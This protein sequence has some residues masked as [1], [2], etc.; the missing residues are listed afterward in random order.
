MG[1]AARAL[2]ADPVLRAGVKT[3]TAGRPLRSAGRTTEQRNVRARIAMDNKPGVIKHLYVLSAY[4]GQCILYSTVK[5]KVTSSGKRLS[6]FSKVQTF[7][8]GNGGYNALA[9]E[10]IQDDGTY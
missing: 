2:A 6:P 9:V 7:G 3:T 8:N 1:C 4:S 10:A 5:G